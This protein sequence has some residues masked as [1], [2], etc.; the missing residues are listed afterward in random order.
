MVSLMDLV[1]VSRVSNA[2][3]IIEETHH[4][5]FFKEAISKYVTP[6][7]V[8]GNDGSKNRLIS[9]HVVVVRN[10]QFQGCIGGRSTHKKRQNVFG[11][12]EILMICFVSGTCLKDYNI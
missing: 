11:G 12:N 1:V 2:S 3:T 10:T 8:R 7:Q 4:V 9:K 5:I 6:L